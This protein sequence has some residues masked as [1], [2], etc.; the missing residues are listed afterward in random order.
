MTLYRHAF[1]F[2]LTVCAL[3]AAIFAVGYQSARAAQADTDRVLQGIPAIARSFAPVGQGVQWKDFANVLA[4]IC[5]VESRCDYTYPHYVNSGGRQ[6]YSQYQGLFQMNVA[7]VARAEQKLQAYL[8]QMQA[9]AEAGDADHKRAFEFVKQAIEAAR[10]LSIEQRRFHP[11]YGIIIGAAKHIETNA[12]LTRQYPGDPLRQAAGHLTAQFSGITER[13]IQNGQFNAA[14]TGVPGDAR[15][16]AGALSVN[17]VSGASTVANAIE[18]AGGVYGERM[19]AMMARMSAVTNGLTTVPTNVRPFDPPSFSGQQGTTPIL[20]VGYGGVSTLMETGLMTPLRAAPFT[21]TSPPS[22]TN[23]PP[24][25]PNTPPTTTT[26]PEQPPP[27]QT[28]SALNIPAAGMILVQPV[29]VQR[30]DSY[31]VSWVS[32]GMSGASPCKVL[33]NGTTLV[34]EGNYGTKTLPA[35]D[36]GAFQLSLKCKTVGG[37]DFQT[38]ARITVY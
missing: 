18:V 30:G 16:E 15:T 31:M 38:G 8:P 3:A 12:V 10:P 28:G 4:G 13:K 14:I 17:R 11:E 37:K 36:L 32:V 2:V 27:P 7:E 9:A 24:Y 5:A 19:R 25:N 29:S 20:G 1:F 35:T 21:P 34:E 22:T 33:L 26:P 6:I 23:I